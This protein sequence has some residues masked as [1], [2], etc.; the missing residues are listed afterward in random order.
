M[1]ATN[2]IKR[3]L[4]T[5]KVRPMVN[6]LPCKPLGPSS[7]TMDILHNKLKDNNKTVSLLIRIKCRLSKLTPLSRCRPNK[8]TLNLR[9]RDSQPKDSLKHLKA[10]ASLRHPK[11]SLRHLKASPRHL[12]AMASPRHLKAMVSPR[13]LKVSLRHLKAMVNLRPLKAM[14]SLK[15]TASLKAMASLKASRVKRAAV[16]DQLIALTI[17]N[18]VTKFRLPAMVAITVDHIEA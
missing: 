11:V 14:A 4:D 10:M 8:H 13:H 18:L 3:W 17:S 9:L 6:T 15:A 2:K 7:K 12:K 16:Q 1:V 5:H